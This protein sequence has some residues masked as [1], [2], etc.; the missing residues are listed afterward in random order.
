MWSLSLPEA[1]SFQLYGNVSRVA[2]ARALLNVFGVYVCV[3][4]LESALPN[5]VS[6]F[7]TV[8]TRSGARHGG[9]GPGPKLEPEV[10]LEPESWKE[11]RFEL[12]REPRGGATARGGGGG[13][14][15]G[16]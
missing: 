8:P 2:Y 10:E 9:G 15:S 5:R 4:V 7:V 14:G 11:L 1:D 16:K 3:R 12:G 6:A 13:G